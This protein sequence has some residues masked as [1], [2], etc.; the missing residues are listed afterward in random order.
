MTCKMLNVNCRQYFITKLYYALRTQTTNI[1]KYN[2]VLFCPY[3]TFKF[4]KY[5]TGLFIMKSF[6]GLLF[7]RNNST[8]LKWVTLV[9][10]GC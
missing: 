1:T 8:L 4:Y 3:L 5:Q 9:K 10:K 6:E 7:L 2:V